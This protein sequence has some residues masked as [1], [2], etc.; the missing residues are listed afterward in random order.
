VTFLPNTGSG[1]AAYRFIVRT[2]LGTV[3]GTKGQTA[4][5]VVVSNDGRIITVYPVK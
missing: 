3:I 4:V 1:A 2:D 5:K